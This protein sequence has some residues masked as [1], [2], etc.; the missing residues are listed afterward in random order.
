[1]TAMR[2]AL[3]LLALAG[4]WVSTLALRIHYSSDAPPCSINEHWDCGTVNHSR[5]AEMDG[6]PVAGIGVIGYTAI[7][8]LLIFD[9]RWS[10]RMVL[11]ASLVGLGF[12][13]YLTSIEANVLHI[14]CLYC[15]T[16]QGIIA[17]ITLAA[18]IRAMGD[19]RRRTA[20]G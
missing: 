17:L 3:M 12:A 20:V 15:V 11:A 10:R 16:S 6:F 4:I 1:M 14:W 2:Y 13:L 19:R 18:F 9:G 7:L 5:F 8:M